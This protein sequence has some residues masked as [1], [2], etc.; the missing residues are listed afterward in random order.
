VA[1]DSAKMILAHSQWKTKLRSAIEGKQQVDSRSAG[2][3][4]Q[5]EMGKWIH[6]E[7]KRY[8]NL[9]EYGDLKTK[10]TTFHA[11]VPKVMTQALSSPSKALDM[12]HPFDG[13]FGRASSNCVNAIM[14][15][16]RALP[17]A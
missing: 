17:K 1:F 5:C 16:E 13:E 15:L 14:S 10:H 12:L 8:A 7:G 3:D 11:C 6:G 2:Q 4:D 9:K